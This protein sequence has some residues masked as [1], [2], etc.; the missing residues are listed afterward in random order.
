MMNAPTAN[1]ASV[2]AFEY[3]KLEAAH[4]G[5]AFERACRERN[6][7]RAELAEAKRRLHLAGIVIVTLGVLL[8]ATSLTTGILLILRYGGG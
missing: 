4:L 8:M 3:L 6:R 1:V 2:A 5:E 7:A